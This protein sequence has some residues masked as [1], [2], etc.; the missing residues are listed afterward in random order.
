MGVQVAGL[1]E[2]GGRGRMGL[3]GEALGLA[4][5]LQGGNSSKEPV[6]GVSVHL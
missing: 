4:G 6:L 5:T 3:R 2:A 1:C